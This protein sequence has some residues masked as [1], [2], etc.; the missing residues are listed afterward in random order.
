MTKG[1]QGRR[2]ENIM[3]LPEKSEV[4]IRPNS[5]SF[6]NQPDNL[7]KVFHE[8]IEVKYFY[9]G[10]STIMVGSE[11]IVTRPGDVIV[12]NPYEF[13]STIDLNGKEGKYH[14]IM[15]GLD[16]FADNNVGGLD[17]RKLLIGKRKCF[18]HLIRGNE[19]M[20]QIL[21]KL[22]E[23]YVNKEEYYMLTVQAL[24]LE[25]FSLLMRYELSDEQTDFIYDESI[26][27]YGI[28]EPAIKKI[29]NSYEQKLSVDDLA[30]L[31]NISKYYFCRIFKLVTN[32]TVMEYITDYRFKIADLMLMH[33]DKTVSEVAQKCGY[34][35]ASYFC[36]C[37]RKKYGISPKKNKEI[38]TQQNGNILP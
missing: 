32:M 28:V 16:F 6:V 19:R 20:A 24:L 31:C 12:I 11:N 7:S 9:E 10:S 8:A 14:L 17:L 21:L 2:A 29:R 27:Y 4:R 5:V 30:A 26:K 37:Y 15:I 23:E 1:T 34:E 36:R 33:S 18:H 22:V 35:D 25:F 38:L 3:L 13:H